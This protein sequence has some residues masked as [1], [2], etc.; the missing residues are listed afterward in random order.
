MVLPYIPDR[1]ICPPWLCASCSYSSFQRGG[2]QG[3]LNA[4]SLPLSYSDEESA[5]YMV[6]FFL[7]LFFKSMP[8]LH[9]E[10]FLFFIEDRWH[11]SSDNFRKMCWVGFSCL[12]VTNVESYQEV[13]SSGTWVRVTCLCPYLPN[14]DFFPGD[15]LR[16]YQGWS[17]GV[18]A[19]IHS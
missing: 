4:S 14:I 15:S 6:L 17:G 1:F 13:I 10:S 9:E 2:C 11:L 18:L 16:S 3:H 19:K 5:H 7:L 12:L 8:V